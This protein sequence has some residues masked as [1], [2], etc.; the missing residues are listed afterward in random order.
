MVKENYLKFTLTA[1]V[2]ILLSVIDIF[3]LVSENALPETFRTRVSIYMDHW[4]HRH[5][6]CMIL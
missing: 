3:C 4:R 6:F 1:L 2:I 5:S